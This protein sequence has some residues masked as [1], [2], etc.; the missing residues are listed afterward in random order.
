MWEFGKTQST[1]D[2]TLYM[3]YNSMS[4]LNKIIIV[5]DV[6]G[7]IQIGNMVARSAGTKSS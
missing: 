4:R 6:Y 7:C 1:F 2:S 3:K 5:T